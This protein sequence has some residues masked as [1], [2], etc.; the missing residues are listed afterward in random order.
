MA[1][2]R[3]MSLVDQSL[4]DEIERYKSTIDKQSDSNDIQHDTKIMGDQSPVIPNPFN[5][6]LMEKRL[7][8]LRRFLNSSLNRKTFP[9]KYGKKL[10][11]YNDALSSL[12]RMYKFQNKMVSPNKTTSIKK[13]NVP[14][15]DP[16]SIQKATSDLSSQLDSKFDTQS[17]QSDDSTESW[18]DEEEED[19]DMDI[20]EKSSNEDDHPEVSI[21]LKS[22][23]PP[24][25]RRVKD[26]MNII[27][28]K[29]GKRITWNEDGTT[30]INGVPLQNSN[31]IDLSR[32]V[33]VM[34]PVKKFKHLDFKVPPGW[35]EFS[36]QLK[37]LNI[38]RSVVQNK[39]RYMDIYGTPA[40]SNSRSGV[41]SLRSPS[42][43]KRKT[44]FSPLL[45]TPK[46]K[47]KSGD[48][49]KAVFSPS[50]ATP[51]PKYLS[52]NRALENFLLKDF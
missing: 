29:A 3:K 12:L 26:L 37:S 1:K 30:F 9:S 22:L 24:G 27:S 25:R 33:T 21:G 15:S 10:R 11:Q 6:F 35:K 5:S 4:L 2:V 50:G 23:N 8:G 51:K 34:R 16:V 47:K 40:I 41:Y 32:E 7:Y 45:S 42:N 17:V 43:I 13:E 46:I 52:R 44:I 36:S 39:R 49:R 31:I 28:E 48:K 38:P 18:L 19:D 20:T 14:Q